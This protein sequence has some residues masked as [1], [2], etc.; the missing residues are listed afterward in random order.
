MKYSKQRNL[1]REKIMNRHDHP[2]AQTIYDEIKTEDN[3]ISLAT[4]YRNLNQLAENGEIRRVTFSG[5]TEHYDP[6]LDEHFHFVCERCGEIKDLSIKTQ[7]GKMDEVIADET[8]GIIKTHD[9]IIRGL[10]KKC[11]KEGM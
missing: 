8:G 1:I 7:F 5:N 3:S 11:K 4:V 9:L 2:T 6:I 10:C